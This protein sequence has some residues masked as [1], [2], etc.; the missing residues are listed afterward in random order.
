MQTSC[1]LTSSEAYSYEATA[2]G[3]AHQLII[4]SAAHAEGQEAE[5][6]L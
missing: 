3:N 2:R 5:R 6:T 4:E 1:M